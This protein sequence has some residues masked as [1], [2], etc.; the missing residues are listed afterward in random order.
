MG[1]AEGI[2]EE[3]ASWFSFF[4]RLKGCG[5]D[6]VNLTA[7]DKC[8]G[9]LEAVSCGRSLSRG[10]IPALYSAFL[11]KRVFGCPHSKMKHVAKI[12]KALHAQER[13]RRPLARRPRLSS[14]SYVG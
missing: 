2:K 10:E 12:L 13:A 7:G 9:L 4:Q 1:L 14:P 5:L 8:L 6:G 3:G 11:S